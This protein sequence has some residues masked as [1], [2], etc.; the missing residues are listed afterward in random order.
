M[1]TRNS[2]KSTSESRFASFE[3]LPAP[4][5]I[6][7]EKSSYRDPWIPGGRNYSTIETYGGF[8]EA[9][10]FSEGRLVGAKAFVIIRL[11]KIGT[12]YVGFRFS[13]PWFVA[14]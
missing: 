1:C 2:A 8:L 5:L 4:R 10:N 7:G 14:R 9:R 12:T 6:V 13:L 3:A 11:H